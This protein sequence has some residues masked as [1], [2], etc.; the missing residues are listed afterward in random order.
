MILNKN[1]ISSCFSNVGYPDQ[2]LNPISET[3]VT[4]IILGSG[5]VLGQI[6]HEIGHSIGFFHEQSRADRDQYVTVNW[7]NIVDPN[8]N[9]VNFQTADIQIE[10]DF[11][12]VPY[13][14]GSIM[15]YQPSVKN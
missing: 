10:N 7:E 5:C 11:L 6:I 15:H 13:D 4:P 2:N 3:I 1:K 9:N 8:R 14:I 12:G